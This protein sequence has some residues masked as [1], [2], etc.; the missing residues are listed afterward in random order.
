MSDFGTFQ[1]A[2][3][4]NSLKIH[5]KWDKDES[6]MKKME[7]LISFL[8]N[9]KNFEIKVGQKRVYV[10][11]SEDFKNQKVNVMFSL[12]VHLFIIQSWTCTTFL[13]KLRLCVI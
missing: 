3:N 9:L 8:P 7:K 5:Y 2:P 1:I 12:T 6:L 11:V 4:V 13:V 10:D